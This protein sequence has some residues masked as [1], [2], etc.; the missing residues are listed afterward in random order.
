MDMYAQYTIMHVLILYYMV[1]IDC[2]VNVVSPKC[3]K[4]SAS[5]GPHDQH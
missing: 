3:I 2:N 4:G 1:C 5:S